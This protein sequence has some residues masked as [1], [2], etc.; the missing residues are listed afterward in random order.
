MRL[1][2]LF[3]AFVF[4][5]ILP[6]VVLYEKMD[7]SN[8]LRTN[9]Y[10]ITKFVD[11]Y[12]DFL[13]NMNLEIVLE[14]VYDFS[15][16]STMTVYSDL[17]RF[18]G[19][20]DIQ[21]RL[22]VLKNHT[23]NIVMLVGSVDNIDFKGYYEMDPCKS[24]VFLNI[25]AKPEIFSAVAEGIRRWMSNILE[26]EMADLLDIG[27]EKKKMYFKQEILQKLQNCRAGK[28][29][30]RKKVVNV[31]EEKTETEAEKKSR[32]QNKIEIRTNNK[33]INNG[34]NVG[35][36]NKSSFIM[37]NK[38]NRLLMPNQ[39]YNKVV[40]Q[41]NTKMSP[42][43]NLEGEKNENPVFQK[44]FARTGNEMVPYGNTKPKNAFFHSY[45]RNI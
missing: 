18:A 8:A 29:T 13:R 32:R 1:I 36:T 34:E 26:S 28:E 12:N 15:T 17:A 41:K 39:R 6:L 35:S 21:G 4:T 7:N 33:M 14:G 31:A 40:M 16:F 24:R 9:I 30:N 20:D 25:L 10:L 19:V 44:G 11:D 38:I 37:P 3:I 23:K 5:E 22:Q 43:D 42:K 2:L 45:I 27:R